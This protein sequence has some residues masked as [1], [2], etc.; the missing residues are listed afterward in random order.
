MENKDFHLHSIVHYSWSD[1]D[2]VLK[3]DG[4]GCSL[5]YGNQFVGGGQRLILSTDTERHMFYLLKVVTDMTKFA[6]CIGEKVCCLLNTY[7]PT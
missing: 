1:D 4:M 6:L 2:G 5:E 3:L 7:L